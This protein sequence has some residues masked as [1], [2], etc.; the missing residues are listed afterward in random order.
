LAFFY[1]LKFPNNSHNHP[2]PP[3][4]HTQTKLLVAKYEYRQK[5]RPRKSY[6]VLGRGNC[7]LLRRYV[8]DFVTKKEI[9]EENR[10]FCKDLD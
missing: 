10:F 1:L 9:L 6:F 8:G 5:N 3:P 7:F 4:H 2:P